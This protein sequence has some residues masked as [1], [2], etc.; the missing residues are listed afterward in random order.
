MKIIKS[1]AAVMLAAGILAGTTSCVITSGNS[2][3]TADETFH[4]PLTIY[5]PLYELDDFIAVVQSRYP[6]IRFEILPYSGANT[7]AFTLEK[8]ECG[9]I[10]D[11]FAMTYNLPKYNDVSD[12]LLDMS[13]FAFTDNFKESCLN[14]VT[15]E[16][17]AIYA[18]P[19]HYQCFG[20][21]YNKTLL[22]KHGWE[23]PENFAD[24]E[25]LSEKAKQAGVRLAL[26]QLQYPGYGFQYFCNICDTGFLSTMG[27]RRWQSAYLNG[28]A[29]ASGSPEMLGC[30]AMLEKW[31][32]IGMLNG[33]GD[34][35][36]DDG[37]K[38]EFLKGNTIFML[39]SDSINNDTSDEFGLM[40]YISEDGKQNVFI[41]NVR[42]YFGLSSSLDQPGNEQK[43]K[44]ALHVMEVFSTVEGMDALGGE[45]IRK[46]SLLPL[47]D[48]P[49]SEDNY[50]YSIAGELSNGHSSPFIYSGWENAIVPVGDEMIAFMT[51]RAE[52]DDVINVI[53]ASQGSVVNNTPEALT[54]VT[55]HISQE[56]CARLV[57][58]A[59]ANST[60]SELALVSLNKWIKGHT[61][62]QNPNGVS[63]SLY[64]VMVTDE[65]I[66]AI[67]P[68]G[69]KGTI[70]TV[71]L[72]GARIRELLEQ[73]FDRYGDGLTY[74]YALVAPDGFQ[75]E[76]DRTYKLAICGVTDEVAAE[77]DIQ[78][79][80]V[81][82]LEAVK[83]MVSEFDELS[84][85][86][87]VWK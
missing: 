39:G 19:C 33:D 36:S 50:Y 47:K 4:E 74:P 80:G 1:T 52:L 86:D 23:L 68:T 37:Q 44:D 5:A 67:V 16:S 77:G 3:E 71:T 42:R 15:V 43:L 46:S 29:N 87:I 73:G 35:L 65:E 32:D 34:L 27:G 22:E 18:L 55:E 31:R 84:A 13:G 51:G 70:S 2:A 26:N 85:D 63:G 54:T 83:Q 45:A 20:I 75:L 59:F 62:T 17:G 69:W 58:T 81:V 76:P 40:P 66:C 8:F 38:Q 11:I 60:G 30:L 82:G 53:D 9:D 28:T 49:I 57:G 21:T 56:D 12:K 48:A 10:P 64:P 14:D 7:T 72:T 78:D 61:N 24:L 41:L 6:E 25:E 79:S